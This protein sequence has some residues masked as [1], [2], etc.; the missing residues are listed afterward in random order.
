MEPGGGD[1]FQNFLASTSSVTPAALVPPA[2]KAFNAPKISVA[3]V[4]FYPAKIFPPIF[5]SLPL[6]P[7]PFLLLLGYLSSRSSSSSLALLRTPPP[8][9]PCRDRPS[10]GGTALS[11]S[12]AEKRNFR[13][14]EDQT[15]S[16]IPPLNPLSSRDPHLPVLSLP[17]LL[18]NTTFLPC[19]T[20]MLDHTSPRSYFY[21]AKE[22]STLSCG[23]TGCDIFIPP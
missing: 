13:R 5:L 20:L 23:L 6:P 7:R 10:H 3:S 15:F 16:S 2:V 1:P 21:P 9:R 22:R 14:L 12:V 17:P 8:R 4:V 19:K 18:R 11:L